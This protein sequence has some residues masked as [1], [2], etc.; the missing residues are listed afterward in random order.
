MTIDLGTPSAVEAEE[1]GPATGAELV[2][3]ETLAETTGVG[4]I[5]IDSNFFDD[6]GLDSLTIAHFCARVRKQAKLP[7]ISVKDCYQHPTIRG[8]AATLPEGAVVHADSVPAAGF[9]PVKRRGAK[10]VS[11][12]AYVLCGAIQFLVFLVYASFAGIVLGVGYDWISAGSGSI[13]VYLRLVVIEGAA[14]AAMCVL[15]IVA[16]W[17]LIGRWKREE[18]PIWSLRYVRF[19]LVST[20]IRLNPMILFTGSPLYPLYLRALGA[21]IGRGV[22]ILSRNAP[23]CTDLLAIGDGAVIRRDAFF[24]GYRAE[25]GVIRTGAVT[26][27]KHAFVGQATVLDID[28]SLGDRCAARPFLIALRGAGDSRRRAASGIAGRA[29]G[30]G[31]PAAHRT[32]GPQ[33]PEKRHLRRTPAGRHAGGLS[34]AGRRRHLPGGHP[35]LAARR[36]A[37]G[38]ACGHHDL[39]VPPQ[40]P[41]RLVRH[42]DRRHCP[43]PADRGHDP[44]PAQPRDQA[45]P[46]VSVVRHPLRRPSVDQRTHQRAR[47]PAAVRRQLLHRPLPALDRVRPLPGR[48]DRV[49]LRH[50]R[51]SREPV[52]DEDRHRGRWSPTASGS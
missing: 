11:T 19:W 3:A 50:R 15:P 35:V 7:S 31:R 51:R 25:A 16:K 5:S 52:P 24:S 37:P 29:A 30:R 1:A 34:A 23:V 41:D 45:R 9:E 49:E 26:I 8:L 32:A 27:G 2:L 44:S 47:V 36:A 38:D 46:A 18:I 40:R 39:G 33:R 13:D 4:S 10:P 42:L 28:T 48:A 21:K 17:T 14:F 20:L 22:V 12:T 6:L 43:W